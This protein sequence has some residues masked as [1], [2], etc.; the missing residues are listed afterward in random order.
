[1]LSIAKLSW[2]M[3]WLLLDYIYIWNQLFKLIVYILLPNVFLNLEVWIFVNKC[4][5]GAPQ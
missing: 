4:R 3:R 5:L 1:M 2:K